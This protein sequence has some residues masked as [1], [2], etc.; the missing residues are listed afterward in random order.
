M[1]DPSTDRA[2]ALS[3]Y[4]RD[5][6]AIFRNVLGPDLIAEA[7]AHIEWLGRRYPDLRPEHYHH[8]LMRDDAFWVRLVTDSRLLDIAELF[9]GPDIACFTSH[10]ICKPA[11][12]GHPV[13]WHQDGAYWDL[14][15]MRAV[16]LWLA[17][18]RSEP[19][20]GCLRMPADAAG[21]AARAAAAA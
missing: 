15:P 8:P 2:S 7:R 10:Y 12:D 16:A 19:E 9:V 6:F 11:R 13:L 21:H 4:E 14:R 20:N 17:I 3:G 1:V 18:D 5:G